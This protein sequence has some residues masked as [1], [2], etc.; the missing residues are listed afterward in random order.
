MPTLLIVLALAAKER[1]LA[2]AREW[3]TFELVEADLAE[4]GVAALLDGID[5]VFHL[6]AEPG[7]R[8]GQL[9]TFMRR[10][11]IATKRLLEAAQAAALAMKQAYGCHGVSTRQH[12]EPAGNQE[13]WHYHLHVFPRYAGD[14]LYLRSNE[15]RY[16]T[17]AERASYAEKLRPLLAPDS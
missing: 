6:A 5:T 9:A 13:V 4:N 11:V 14:D 8:G 1:N 15:K 12:N 16:T 3:D 2:H 10:N 17:P 7:V